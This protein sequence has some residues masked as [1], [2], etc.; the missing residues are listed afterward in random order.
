MVI[1]S[2][3]VINLTGSV[4]IPFRDK[5]KMRQ[6]MKSK[7]LLLHLILKQGHTWYLIVYKIIKEY[8]III[9]WLRR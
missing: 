5:F 4:I 8:I 7:P 1:L 6:I 9:R 3:N 2:G